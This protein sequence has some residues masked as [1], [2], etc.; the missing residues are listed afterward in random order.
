M[1]GPG[2]SGWREG[3]WYRF[4]K[5]G[6]MGRGPILWP[7]QMVP[8]GSFAFFLFFSLFLFVFPLNFGLKSFA[9]LLICFKLVFGKR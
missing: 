5:G 7:D 2:V 4:G 8:R 1:W 9:K 3:A 6:K